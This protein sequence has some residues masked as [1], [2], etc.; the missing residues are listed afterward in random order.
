VRVVY[1]CLQ[2]SGTKAVGLTTSFVADPVVRAT[3][4]VLHFF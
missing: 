4:V 1:L 2:L 3:L